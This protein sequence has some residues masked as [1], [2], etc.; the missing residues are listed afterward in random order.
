MINKGLGILI[1]VMGVWHVNHAQQIPTFYS[2]PEPVLSVNSRDSENYLYL[3]ASGD[4]LIFHQR[5]VKKQS[6]W[7]IESWRYLVCKYA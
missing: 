1:L 6:R 4:E 2:E 5:K 7:A 3:S